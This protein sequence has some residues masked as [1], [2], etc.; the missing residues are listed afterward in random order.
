MTRRSL[1][2]YRSSTSQ[3]VRMGRCRDRTFDLTRNITSTSA[4]RASCCTPPEQSSKAARFVTA[5]PSSTAMAVRSKCGVVPTPLHGKFHVISMRMHAMSP[6]HWQRPR[7]SSS[8]GAIANV[9]RCYSP[10]SSAFCDSVDF[11][12]A[13]HAARKMNLRSPQSRRTFADLP[14]WLF[15]RRRR[16]LHVL[17]SSGLSPRQ[18]MPLLQR[19][20]G[21]RPLQY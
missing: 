11:D 8:H 14:S 13:A 2:I 7:R 1:R 15:A 20:N 3:P 12:C 6:G 21:Q 16:S 10:I 17:R 5:P 19:G 4:Q 18:S 9:W